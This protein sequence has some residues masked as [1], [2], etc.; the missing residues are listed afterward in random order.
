[1]ADENNKPN[2]SFPD[3]G[4]VVDG[5]DGRE[6]VVYDKNDDGEVIGWHKELKETE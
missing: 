6:L 3:E 5:S 4:S 1:M 2:V